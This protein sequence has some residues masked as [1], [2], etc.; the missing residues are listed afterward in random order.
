MKKKIALLLSLCLLFS[1]AAYALAAGDAS[2]PL[3]SLSY[4]NGTFTSTVNSK[5]DEKLLMPLYFLDLVRPPPAA[6]L[7]LTGPRSA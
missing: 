2:D 6:P 4:L 1:V 7:L 5:V 3:A